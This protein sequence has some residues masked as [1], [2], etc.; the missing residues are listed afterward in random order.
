MRGTTNSRIMP[1]TTDTWCPTCGMHVTA[2]RFDGGAWHCP[3][4]N[5]TVDTDD[6]A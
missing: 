6:D 2:F 3:G 1:D 5:H 4:G